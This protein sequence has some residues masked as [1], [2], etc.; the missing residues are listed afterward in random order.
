VTKVNEMKESSHLALKFHD[1]M[2][3]SLHR[4]Q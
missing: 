2:K 4:L 3:I 1:F